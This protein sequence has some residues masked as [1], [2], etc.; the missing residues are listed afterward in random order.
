VLAQQVQQ[1]RQLGL[2]V[3]VIGDDL[4]RIR[5]EDREQLVVGQAQQILELCGLQSGWCF[6]RRDEPYRPV[7]GSSGFAGITA[8]PDTLA[9]IAVSRSTASEYTGCVALGL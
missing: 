6:S 5:V 2:V 9:V 7:T 3:E 8:T 1:N 4:E